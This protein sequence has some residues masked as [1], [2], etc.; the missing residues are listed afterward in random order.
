VRIGAS[1]GVAVSAVG[2]GTDQLLAH[3]DVA[4]YAAKATGKSAY[5]RYDPS[6]TPGG[7]VATPAFT[8]ELGAAAP[9]VRIIRSSRPGSLGPRR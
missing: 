7:A 4:M 3:A 6:M 5:R 9:S 2:M 8:L 1:I